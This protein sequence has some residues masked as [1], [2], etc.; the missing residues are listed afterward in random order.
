MA[1]KSEYKYIAIIDIGINNLRSVIGA[2]NYLG[3]KTLITKDKNE[4]M[5]SVALILPGVGSFPSGMKNLKKNGLDLTVKNFFKQGKP[6][7]AICLGYQMIFSS[8]KEFGHTKGLNIIEGKVKSLKSLKTSSISPNLGWNKLNYKRSSKN[9][10][11]K[12][13]KNNPAFY[14]IHSYYAELK[15]KKYITSTV[16]FGG[17]KI[18]TSVQYKNLYGVQFHPEKSSNDG[19]KIIKNFLD[20]IRL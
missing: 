4:I 14:F 15:N 12:N 7:L 13:I 2:L 9:Y 20:Q 10:L 8:S 6:I 3:F 18:T 17:K 1:L 5:N 19:M 16:N 11:F